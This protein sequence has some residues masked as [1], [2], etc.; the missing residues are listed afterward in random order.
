MNRKQKVQAARAVQRLM[1]GDVTDLVM[2]HASQIQVIFV[3]MGMLI[4]MLYEGG[5][6]DD[7]QVDKLAHP[8]MAARRDEMQ[9]LTDEIIKIA[10]LNTPSGGQ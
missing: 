10:G 6:L 5:A 1:K 9:K 3:V 7:A 2:H 8:D 4:E